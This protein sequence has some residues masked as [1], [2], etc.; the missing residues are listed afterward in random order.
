MNAFEEL[1]DTTEKTI[2]KEKI[3]EAFRY[4]QDE[5]D[6]INLSMIVSILQDIGMQL[7]STQSGMTLGTDSDAASS[8]VSHNTTRQSKPKAKPRP[9]KKGK[10]KKR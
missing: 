9:R 6:K 8:M 1:I 2:S 10:K 4:F 3:I 7:F 5:H